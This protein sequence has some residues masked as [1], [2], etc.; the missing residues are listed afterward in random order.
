MTENEVEELLRVKLHKAGIL[1]TDLDAKKTSLF[2]TPEGVLA[3]VVLTDGSKLEQAEEAA[4]EA[5]SELEKQGVSLLPTVRTRWCVVDVKPQFN[6]EELPTRISEGFF[7]LPYVA[8]LKSGSREQKVGVEIMPGADTRTEAAAK[9]N[10]ATL[11]NFVKEELEGWLSVGGAG[12]WDPIREPRR[13]VGG[14]TFTCTLAT[15]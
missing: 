12:Y 4:E 1:D 11:R 10:D 3:D 15:Q 13:I 14:P 2:L 6:T 9:W 5:K 8:T 7:G